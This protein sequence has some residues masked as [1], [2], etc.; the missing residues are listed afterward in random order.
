M[1]DFLNPENWYAFSASLGGALWGVTLQPDFKEIDL[2]TKAWR[3]ALAVVAAVFL[4][5]ALL[6]TYFQNAAPQVATAI[7]FSVA[8]AA[9]T[10]VPVV[11]RRIGLFA[12]TGKLWNIPEDRP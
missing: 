2:R 1:N 4:G 9:L 3:F 10:V 8:L 11:L 7:M 6:H 5:P 12:K